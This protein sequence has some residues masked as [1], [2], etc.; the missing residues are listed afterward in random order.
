[1]KV[2]YTIA[3]GRGETNILLADA[4]EKLA[5]RGLRLAGTVQTD[6][7][8]ADSD[9]CDMDVQVLPDGP[10]IRISQN[11]GRDSRGC[12]LDADALEQAVALTGKVLQ[13]GADLLIVNKFGRHEAEGRGFR[14]A[15]GEALARDIPV[16]AGVNELN[17]DAFVQFCGGA[18]E[19]I[20]PTSDAILEWIDGK[21]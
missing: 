14:E 2:A 16:L 19:R 9:R 4:A 13:G 8:N 20:D 6:C 21:G 10:V 1:M 7:E 15:I 5:G 3:P 17:E 11:L 18:A 12:R